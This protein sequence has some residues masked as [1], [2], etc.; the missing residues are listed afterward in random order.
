MDK[1]HDEYKKC[2]YKYKTVCN[3]STKESHEAIVLATMLIIKYLLYIVEVT[4]G[5]GRI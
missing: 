1:T 3:T 5:V 4:S 2:K